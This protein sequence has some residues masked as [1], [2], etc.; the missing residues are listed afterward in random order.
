LLN[1][2]VTYGA[3]PPKLAETLGCSLHNARLAFDLFWKRNYALGQLRDRIMKMA[4]KWGFIPGIDGRKIYVRSPHSALNALFQSAGSICMKTAM[5]LLDET[6]KSEGI[7]YKKL[8][9][10]HDES[11]AEVPESEII[12]I[13]EDELGN[14]ENHILS[15]TVQEGKTGW[16]RYGEEAIKSIR[17][18]GEQLGIRIMLDGEYKL[19]RNWAETH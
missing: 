1:I 4:E 8:L 18:A 6:C 9:D 12:W 2:D 17:R 3:Q 7:Y 19:G 14:Y 16:C 13:P 5:V 10:M 11:Q 15:K